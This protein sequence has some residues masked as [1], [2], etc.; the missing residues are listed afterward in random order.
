MGLTKNCCCSNLKY[1]H[2][3]TIIL[4]A[5]L[6]P[7]PPLI[8]Y[9]ALFINGL[10]YLLS[11]G[12]RMSSQPYTKLKVC[13]SWPPVFQ[14]RITQNII[15]PIQIFLYHQVYFLARHPQWN[16]NL[17]R[18]LNPLKRVIICTQQPIIDV[19]SYIPISHLQTSY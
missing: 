15:Q 17:P 1:S 12:Y 2:Y 3:A 19:L 10:P 13:L 16:D 8:S 11:I 5:I 9:S 7:S 18:L 14:Q 6:T 4:Q